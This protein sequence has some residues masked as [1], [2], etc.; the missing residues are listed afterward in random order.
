MKS[1]GVWV[2]G[3]M[4]STIAFHRLDFISTGKDISGRRK[5]YYATLNKEDLKAVRAAVLSGLGLVS[6]TKHL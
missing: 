2:K 3:D 4:V 6:L 1:N 5:Y